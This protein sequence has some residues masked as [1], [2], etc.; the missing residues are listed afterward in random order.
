MMVEAGRQKHASIS[1]CLHSLHPS[2]TAITHVWTCTIE[3]NILC[4]RHHNLPAI[5]KNR[6]R[7]SKSPCKWEMSM[8]SPSHD[9]STKLGEAWKGTPQAS[10][11]VIDPS[12]LIN[13]W[14]RSGSSQHHLQPYNDPN[15]LPH[16]SKWYVANADRIVHHH[17]PFS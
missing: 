1:G 15:H 16:H 9:V 3:E 2:V 14:M 8:S 10:V 6:A 5:V 17:D 11:D 7:N 12:P 13:R 4:T